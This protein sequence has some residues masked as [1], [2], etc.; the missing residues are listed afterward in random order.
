MI[1]KTL[2]NLAHN[3][4]LCL[5]QPSAFIFEIISVFQLARSKQS[6]KKKNNEHYTE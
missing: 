3:E 4:Y 1:L 2:K 5:Y 6:Y